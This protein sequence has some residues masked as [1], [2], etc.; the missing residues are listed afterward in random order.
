MTATAVKTKRATSTRKILER[1]IEDIENGL[2]TCGEM[3]E[4]TEGPKPMGCALGL[5]GINSGA[6]PVEEGPD[7]K[8]YA[9]ITYPSDG[10]WTPQALKALDLMVDTAR[11][12]PGT[13]YLLDRKRD[14]IEV[15]RQNVDNYGSGDDD[16]VAAKEELVYAL[17]DSNGMTPKRALSWFRRALAKLDA[18]KS[19]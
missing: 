17:N 12:V 3:C 15:A 8:F 5:L 16:V 7:G 1:S 13:K 11:A 18:G 19:A 4:A 10:A 2:W 9:S 14:Q 6:F